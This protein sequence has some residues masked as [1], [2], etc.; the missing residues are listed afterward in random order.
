MTPAPW[1]RPASDESAVA[2]TPYRHPPPPTC[3]GACP[4]DDDKGGSLPEAKISVCCLSVR[5][6]SG[7]GNSG[8]IGISP[9]RNTVRKHLRESAFIPFLSAIN[10]F[11]GSN[12][13]DWPAKRIL[14]RIRKRM[15]ADSRRW[16]NAVRTVPNPTQHIIALSFVSGQT[17]RPVVSFGPGRAVTT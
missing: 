3:S 12:A 11:G 10:S 4:G 8:R 15:N 6:E 7:N 16:A 9:D 2:L 13:R 14:A 5:P 1:R 17:P